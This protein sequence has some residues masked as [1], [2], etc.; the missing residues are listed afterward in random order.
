MTTKARRSNQCAQSR[1]RRHIDVVSTLARGIDLSGCPSRLETHGRGRSDSRWLLGVLAGAL[2]QRRNARTDH[3]EKL[4]AEALDDLVGAVADVASGD[5]G[6]QRRYAGATSR[7]V[8]HGSPELVTAFH[9]FQAD[10]TTSTVDGRR[11]FMH[12]L[13][14]ARRE[15]GRPPVDEH[16][17]RMLLFGPG[18]P[19]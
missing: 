9:M 15:L 12:A 3:A 19:K 13:Q 5:I 16:A 8:L 6:A 11:R 7:I 17:A 2:L 10:A 4:L 1:G 14:V 18:D